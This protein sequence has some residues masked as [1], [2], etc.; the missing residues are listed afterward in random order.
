ML[1]TE[2]GTVARVTSD[3]KPLRK[4]LFMAVPEYAPNPNA[5]T[6]FLSKD[7]VLWSNS[8]SDE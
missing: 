6:S 4:R 2:L 1:W 3:V 7:V 5:T 8:D